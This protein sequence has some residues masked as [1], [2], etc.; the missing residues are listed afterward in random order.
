LFI[1]IHY[2]LDKQAAIAALAGAARNISFAM[3]RFLLGQGVGLNK[4]PS[5]VTDSMS[6]S[7][8]FREHHQLPLMEAAARG[9]V[10]MVLFLLR[11]GAD[12]NA[13]G[14]VSCSPWCRVFQVA[15]R[16]CRSD[17]R[18]LASRVFV[19]GG[20]HSTD[21]SGALWSFDNCGVFGGDGS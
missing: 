6:N 8:S 9:H 3:V 7:L 19:P 11:R 10:P 17:Q 21:G 4:M 2:C 1:T 18:F 12:V 16:E 13:Q 15:L 14:H 20:A 5:H